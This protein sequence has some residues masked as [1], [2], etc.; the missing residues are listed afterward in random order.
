VSTDQPLRLDAVDWLLV[1]AIGGLAAYSSATGP[2][3]ANSPA[4]ALLVAFPGL[5]A[6]FAGWYYMVKALITV[7][8][9]P[10]V[11]A[12]TTKIVGVL[13]TGL[14]GILVSKLFG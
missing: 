13:S 8:T 11:Q 14:A 2:D 9:P 12:V 10:G 4:F 5:T 3:A 1:I 6:V 7:A